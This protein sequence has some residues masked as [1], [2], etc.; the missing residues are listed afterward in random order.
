MASSKRFLVGIIFTLL[1][2]ISSKVSARQLADPNS[3]QHTKLV[4]ESKHGSTNGL[5]HPTAYPVDPPG[6]GDY[7]GYPPRSPGKA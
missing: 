5:L 4:K 3:T 7:P 6:Y 1:F 2:L